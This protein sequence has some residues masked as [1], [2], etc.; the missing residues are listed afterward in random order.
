M[1]FNE[2]WKKANNSEYGFP[3]STVI[4]KKELVQSD[5]KFVQ[6]FLKELEE[7]CNFAAD[8][9]SDLPAY[10]EEIGVS[11][12]KDIVSK[13]IE[14]A[15]IKYVAI[16]DCYKEYDTYF[17]KLKELDPKTIGGKVP[18]EGVYMEK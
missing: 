4:V 5:N 11:V 14:K 10:C 6:E 8:N 18:D 3:Q 15:N 17:N 9:N 12:N 1:D 2:E 16:K 13:S 7:S